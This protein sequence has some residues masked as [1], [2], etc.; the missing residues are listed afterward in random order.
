MEALEPELG[1][2]R[3]HLALVRGDPLAAELVRLAADLDVEQAP[4]D[5]IARLEH[6][7]LA[8]R[9]GEIG[10]RDE[11]GDSGAD[12]DDISLPAA[13]ARSS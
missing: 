5:A 13:H 3:V 8:A 1:E 9:R 12:D 11:A 4:A 7:D 6:D 10:G 2:E